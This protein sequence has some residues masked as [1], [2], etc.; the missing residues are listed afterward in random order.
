MLTVACTKS[1]ESVKQEHQKA[2]YNVLAISTDTTGTPWMYARTE[3]VGL[4]IAEDDKLKAELMSFS[5]ING[6][7]HYMVRVTSKISCDMT[8]NWGWDGLTIDEISPNNNLLLANEVKTFEL[9][10]DAKIGKIK[11]QGQHIGNDCPNSSTLIINITMQILPIKY[12]AYS[13]KYD[14]KTGDVTISFEIDDPTV[15]DRF[16]IQK[17]KEGKISELMNFKCDKKTKKYSIPI[18]E[19]IGK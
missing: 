7:A 9:I 5:N 11:V 10:G 4:V 15:I 16:V 2:Y 8:L 19:G 3:T 1:N 12:I 13:T 6:H 14:E 17:E 18:W